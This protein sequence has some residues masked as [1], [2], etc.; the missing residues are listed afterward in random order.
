MARKHKAKWAVMPDTGNEWMNLWAAIL[1]RALDDVRTGFND[2]D[3][4]YAADLFL[5]DVWPSWR[6]QIGDV[7]D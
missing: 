3:Q 7:G 4:F 1:R 5:N 2:D 6:Q